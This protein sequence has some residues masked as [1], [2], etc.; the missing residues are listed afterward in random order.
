M[1]IALIGLLVFLSFTSTSAYAN[2]DR[3]ISIAR[4]T[5]SLDRNITRTVEPIINNHLKLYPDDSAAYGQ[6]SRFIMKTGTVK[7]NSFLGFRVTDEADKRALAALEK[8]LELDP[9]NA[10]EQSRLGYLHAV[11]GR[12]KEAEKIFAT[13][14]SD[15]EPPLWLDYDKAIVAVGTGDHEAAATLLD[16]ITKQR[17]SDTN[18][19]QGWSLYRASW[20]LRK[21]LALKDSS[22]DPVAAIRDGKMRRVAL[23]DFH[24]EARS[25][26]TDKPIM[27]FLS[28]GDSGCPP[29]V[30]D[31]KNLSAIADVLSKEYDLIY[32]SIEPWN[33]I[34]NEKDLVRA[35]QIRGVPTHIIMYGDQRIAV[36]DG[37][38]PI[39]GVTAYNDVVPK[40]LSGEFNGPK[41]E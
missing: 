33:D 40:I 9:Q 10:S 7:D 15:I 8:A 4:I 19:F 11:Q 20:N 2:R 31:S 23:Q 14:S 34:N 1:K 38:F 26:G 25:S 24:K 22:T 13:I 41:V 27:A 32:A 18:D 36:R 5:N 17:P 30:K 21:T 29:C 12:Y 28:S 39:D 3:D 6:L 35:F 37:S 16:P